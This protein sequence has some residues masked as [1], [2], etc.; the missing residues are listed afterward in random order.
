MF[1]ILD[2]YKAFFMFSLLF[3]QGIWADVSTF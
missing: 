3:S 1:V 2:I